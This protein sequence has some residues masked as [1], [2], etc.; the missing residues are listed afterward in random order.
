MRTA[1]RQQ[2]STDCATCHVLLAE[3]EENPQILTTLNGE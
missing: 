2:I 1:D 3:D